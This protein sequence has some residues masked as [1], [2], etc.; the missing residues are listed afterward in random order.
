[1]KRFVFLWI[2]LLCLNACEQEG[3]L[4]KYDV[5]LQRDFQQRYRYASIISVSDWDGS[6]L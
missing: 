4:D 6:G 1:M 5:S 3:P 2:M